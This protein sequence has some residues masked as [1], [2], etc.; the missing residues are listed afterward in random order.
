M[1]TE[2]TAPKVEVTATER[3]LSYRYNQLCSLM[4][5]C[6]IA[7]EAGSWL[8]L[9]SALQH[10]ILDADKLLTSLSDQ[11]GDLIGQGVAHEYAPP[12]VRDDV[13]HDLLRAGA[14]RTRIGRALHA[15]DP[16]DPNASLELLRAAADGLLAEIAERGG[17]VLL[18][19]DAPQDGE[20]T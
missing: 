2:T 1:G 13:M 4:T 6:A 16:R 5:T 17:P 12:A 20:L 8:H 11:T 19:V 15:V 10:L 7:V 18:I 9:W 14:Q 3:V